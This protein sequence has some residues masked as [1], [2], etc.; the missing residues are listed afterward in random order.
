MRKNSNVSFFFNP[1]YVNVWLKLQQVGFSFFAVLSYVKTA[2]KRLRRRRGHSQKV[3]VV[4]AREEDELMRQR[5]DETSQKSTAV[6]CR[7]S[8]EGRL[9]NS[10]VDDELNT[11]F[12]HRTRI[13]LLTI[14]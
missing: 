5:S 4:R 3:N 9:K 14:S 13:F 12:I 1:A 11:L 10:A 7:D 2:S 6:P 8:P